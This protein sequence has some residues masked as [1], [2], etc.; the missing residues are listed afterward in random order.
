M[1]CHGQLVTAITG[2]GKGGV[3][4]AENKPAVA[5]AMTVEHRLLHR[6]GEHGAAGAAVLHRD[7]KVLGRQVANV[8][9]AGDGSG[10]GVGRANV[11]HAG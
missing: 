9:F 10:Q 7:A 11:G 1:L 4:Q 3:C 5:A 6:H 2:I 8:K